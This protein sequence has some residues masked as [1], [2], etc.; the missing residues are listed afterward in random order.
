[1]FGN[2]KWWDTKVVVHTEGEKAEYLKHN[3]ELMGCILVSNADGIAGQRKFIDD[4]VEFDEWYLSGDD[5]IEAITGVTGKNYDLPGQLPDNLTKEN[6]GH[7]YKDSETRHLM[8]EMMKES[9]RI[10]CRLFGFSVMDNPFFR[11][12]KL[13]TN[14]VINAGLSCTKKSAE[15]EVDTDI[16]LKEDY[17]RTAKHLLYHG[18]TLRND[19]VAIKTKMYTKGGVGS[20]KDREREYEQ[21]VVKLMNNYPGLFR[22]NMSRNNPNAEVRIVPSTSQQVALWRLQMILKGKLPPEYVD[23]ILNPGQAMQFKKKYNL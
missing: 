2:E 5:D 18:I 1:V 7:E 21:S 20:Y 19:Y 11:S 13:R 10:G 12:T 8:V 23:K 16:R 6:Y 22:K 9:E 14:T 17:E 3:P 4:Q 15:W